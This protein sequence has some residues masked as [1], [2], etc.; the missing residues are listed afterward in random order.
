[1]KFDIANREFQDIDLQAAKLALVGSD[2]T[3]SW[4]EFK[5]ETEKLLICLEKLK[6]EIG[7]PVFVYGH[8][9]VANIVAK[10]ALMMLKLPYVPA[11]IIFP[12][13]RIKMMKEECQ[14]HVL[15]N[16]TNSSDLNELFDLVIQAPEFII[17][18]KNQ[19]KITSLNH[20]TTSD[21]PI[22]YILFTSGS[23]G[24]PKGVPICEK[25]VNEFAE[26]LKT[27]FKLNDKDVILNVSALSFDFASYE[28]YSFLEL[29]STLVLSDTDT[30]KNSK[31]LIKNIKEYQ[32]NVWVSTPSLVFMYLME[33][34]F[35]T[36]ALP[37]IHTF[38]FA[39]EA[40]P[41]RTVKR[42]HQLFPNTR[43]INAFGPTEATNLTS[44]IELTPAI[45]EKYNAVPIGTPKPHSEVF[46]IDENE[47]GIGEIIIAGNH[48]TIGYLNNEELN[49]EK[50]Y[51]YKTYRAYKTGD[52]GFIKDGILFY[53]GRNDNM[54][55]L[56]G[57]RIELE[58]INSKLKEIKGV[59]NAV[60]IGLKHNG[61]TKKIVSLVVRQDPELKP[62]QLFIAL[63]QTLPAYMLPADI[64]FISE[65]P[66]NSSDKTD[67]K[68]LQ[69]IYL[70]AL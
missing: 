69:E 60:T 14:A 42:L 25:G 21:N 66:L 6:L 29:G 10:T 33:P 68:Q 15:I 18:N 22:N 58:D 47:E 44:K 3:L 30:I 4:F 17:T 46:I 48:V 55:K 62:E 54:V 59:K 51:N 70:N 9:E 61:E 65:I 1:M 56:H 28:E 52:F 5:R 37:S 13:E 49:N 8:K 41:L 27:D 31:K 38:V 26:W 64:K 35:N 32:V 24:K 63:K 2:K 45:I 20:L 19:A 40:L 16:C 53:V 23:T 67:L 7:T 11:D 57:Y 34:E 12:L 50:F 43:I 39:G 36:E